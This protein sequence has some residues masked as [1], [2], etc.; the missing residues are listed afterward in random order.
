[1]LHTEEHSLASKLR[2]QAS[3]FSVC[4]PLTPSAWS[5]MLEAEPN[6]DEHVAITW[7]VIFQMISPSTP[8]RD[9][10]ESGHALHMDEFLDDFSL[11]LR[12]LLLR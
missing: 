5:L 6:A 3:L 11:P 1:M 4:S 7:A 8:A 2:K 9:T 12:L 10:W